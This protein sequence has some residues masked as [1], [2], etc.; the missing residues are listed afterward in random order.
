MLRSVINIYFNY[1]KDQ[2]TSDF[3]AFPNL[4]PQNWEAFLAPC[5]PLCE[6]FDYWPFLLQ[7]LVRRILVVFRYTISNKGSTSRQLVLKLYS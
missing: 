6:N 7:L 4:L 1:R 5:H 2:M 3:A